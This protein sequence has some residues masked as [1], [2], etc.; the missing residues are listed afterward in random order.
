[1]ITQRCT[2]CDTTLF[3]VTNSFRYCTEERLECYY[4]TLHT[5]M[6]YALKCQCFQDSVQNANAVWYD[7]LFKLQPDWCAERDTISISN[8]T[9]EGK[10]IENALT[11][12]R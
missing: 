12:N 6:L 11:P 3:R 10:K 1:M 4:D 8:F 7:E 5:G 2:D 9:I